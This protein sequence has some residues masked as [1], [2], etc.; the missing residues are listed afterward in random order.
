MT[1]TR[2]G[3]DSQEYQPLSL[4]ELKE[5][6]ESLIWAKEGTTIVAFRKTDMT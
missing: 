3:Y 5:I 4:S 1:I 2:K 6:I